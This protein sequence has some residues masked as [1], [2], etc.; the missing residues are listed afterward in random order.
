MCAASCGASGCRDDDVSTCCPDE[1]LG[2]C[3]LD[4]GEVVCH[5]C[6]DGHL[7]L[8]NGTCIPDTAQCPENTYPTGF[9]KEPVCGGD[10]RQFR[11][12]EAPFYCNEMCLANDFEPLAIQNGTCVKICTN[13][14]APDAITN[15]CPPLQPGQTVFTRAFFTLCVRARARV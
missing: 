14:E 11:L 10:A 13:G 6:A 9:V 5:A 12:I 1:C 8:S 3:A 4:G 7:V 2:G 15:E